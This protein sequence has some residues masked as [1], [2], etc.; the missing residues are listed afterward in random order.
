MSDLNV[1]DPITRPA[2]TRI[3]ATRPSP[4]RRAGVAGIVVALGLVLL[5]SQ[6]RA[7]AD[8]AVTYV[9]DQLGQQRIDFKPADALTPEERSQPCLAEHAGA[10]MTTGRQ[11]ECYATSFIGQH[12]PKIANGKTFAELRGVQTSLR[13]DLAAAQAAGDPS[14]GDL[15]RQLNEVTAKRQSLFEGETMKG[16]LLTTYGFSTLGAKAAQAAT[17]SYGAA[18][19]LFLAS[20]VVLV[21][22]GRRARVR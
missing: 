7:D 13:A 8:F 2:P 17:V 3:S 16:L 22:A 18:A 12:L 14:A 21:R 1:A 4:G 19:A 9:A 6:M 15:Q 11:A 20:I 5:G 10:R